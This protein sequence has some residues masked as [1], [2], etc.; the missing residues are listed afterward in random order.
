MQ[1]K[2]HA[3]LLLSL[4]LVLLL[5]TLLIFL[6][7]RA[8][9]REQALRDLSDRVSQQADLRPSHSGTA[10]STTTGGAENG[11]ALLSA[12][13]DLRL[14]YFGHSL[15]A[16]RGYP[17]EEGDA[18]GIAYPSARTLYINAL[19]AETSLALGGRIPPQ[20]PTD[21]KA[22]AEDFLRFTALSL[23]E[24]A[25]S[26]RLVILFPAEE[27][28]TPTPSGGFTGEL[29]RDTEAFIRTVRAT[30]PACD[31]LL[32]I[33]P[34]TPADDAERLVALGAY[35][36]CR[37]CDLRPLAA[38]AGM[39]HGEGELFGLPTEA[40]HTAIADA[41]LEET[42]AA[43]EEEASLPPTPAEWLY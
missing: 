22:A 2:Q 38:T 18:V 3:A 43:M 40:G 9:E 11:F 36:G 32:A 41:L 39:L 29:C 30:T 23:Q 4:L 31:I 7:V 17:D 14:F 26:V 20:L 5:G 16:G 6:L 27:N 19:R 35:Y 13:A 28:C 34:D 42:L 25:P 21:F 15:L 24:A 33:A 1:K 8:G 10:G 12:G 37:V